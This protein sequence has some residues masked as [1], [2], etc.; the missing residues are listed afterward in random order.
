MAVESDGGLLGGGGILG[1]ISGAIG[2]LF[3]SDGLVDQLAYSRDEQSQ[4]A[5]AQTLANAQ[6][7][8]AQGQAAAANKPLITKEQL[9]II[10]Y[11]IGGLMLIL[12]LIF[13]V[14]WVSR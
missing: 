5:I 9:T 13:L 12:L 7:T 14:R 1:I 10:G 6:L 8:Y 3:G 2:P 4:N 11:L